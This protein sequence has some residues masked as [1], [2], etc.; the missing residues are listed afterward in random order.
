VSGVELAHGRNRNAFPR[1]LVVELST[2][3]DGWQV[4]A[5]RRFDR[6]PIEAFLRPLEFPLIV[7]FEPAEARYL[8]L[9]NTSPHARA[10]WLIGEIRIW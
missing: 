4:V 10:S 6:L 9:T 2:A 5:E 3:A 7:E 1:G 8:R